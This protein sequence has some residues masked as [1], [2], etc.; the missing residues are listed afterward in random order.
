MAGIA[1]PLSLC[2]PSTPQHAAPVFRR[3]QGPPERVRRH[4]PRKGESVARMRSNLQRSL[5]PGMGGGVLRRHG[6]PAGRAEQ[7]QARPPITGG[8]PVWRVRRRLQVT[9]EFISASK[10]VT[11]AGPRVAGPAPKASAADARAAGGSRSRMRTEAHPAATQT[12]GGQ[13][14][15]RRRP[16]AAPVLANAAAGGDG[17]G[18]PDAAGLHAPASA[19]LEDASSE[20]ED[21]PDLLAL[22]GIQGKAT[23]RRTDRGW[24]QGASRTRCR[25][26]RAL[27]PHRDVPCAAMCRPAVASADG[28]SVDSEDYILDAAMEAMLEDDAGCEDDFDALESDAG[29]AD[30]KR[31]KGSSRAAAGGAPPVSA[32]GAKRTARQ[33]GGAAAKGADEQRRARG[34]RGAR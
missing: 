6:Q 22:M 3:L 25:P 2:V 12:K 30:A 16:A 9:S 4:L 23:H 8:G 5:Q 31:A 21:G 10:E 33:A 11:A 27:G 7:Q 19:G 18:G 34:R 24:R 14:A 17:G 29:R 1:H 32:W 20:E 28:D 15:A 13:R 26:S